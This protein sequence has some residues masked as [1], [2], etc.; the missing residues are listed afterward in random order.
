MCGFYRSANIIGAVVAQ[1]LGYGLD[2]SGSV[3]G[4]GK[5]E[6]SF[7]Y[8]SVQTGSGSHPASYSLGTVGSFPENKVAGVWS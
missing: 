5:E 6:I 4:R 3:P 8:H 2:D 1:W 7:L